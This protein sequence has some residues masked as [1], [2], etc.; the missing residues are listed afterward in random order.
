LASLVKNSIH[1]FRVGFLEVH[2]QKLLTLTAVFKIR[3]IISPP[4]PNSWEAGEL[5][6]HLCQNYS[7][8]YHLR[9]KL[10]GEKIVQATPPR[11]SQVRFRF[12]HKTPQNAKQPPRPLFAVWCAHEQPREHWTSPLQAAKSDRGRSIRRCSNAPRGPERRVAADAHAAFAEAAAQDGIVLAPQ[13]YYTGLDLSWLTTS[14]T[15]GLMQYL[16]TV[17]DLAL[18][19]DLT[20]EAFPFAIAHT[21]MPER[22]R[23]AL[24]GLVLM[25]EKRRGA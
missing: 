25:Y 2:F 24:T 7:D 23:E 14:L 12:S 10:R 18:T 19:M 6:G 17:P 22:L 16:A 21:D 13:A 20:F 4:E 5:F 8:H 11:R 3:S 1:F 15:T 9:R